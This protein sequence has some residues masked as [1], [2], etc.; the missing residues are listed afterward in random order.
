MAEQPGSRDVARKLERYGSLTVI[1]LLALVVAAIQIWAAVASTRRVE[2]IVRELQALQATQ[3]TDEKARQEVLSLKIENELKSFFWNSLLATLGPVV[4]TFG[5][6][7]GALL[8]LRNYLDARDKERLDRAAV[9]LNTTLEHLMKEEPR[10]RAVGVVGLQH[11][12]DPEEPRHHLRALSALAA[13]ARLEDDPE[14]LRG[15]RIAAEQAFRTLPGEVLGRV[16]W[17]GAK[18]RGLD[19]SGRSLRRIDLRDADLE[20]AD[21]A[22]CDLAGASLANARLNGSRLDGAILEGANLEYAD[23]AGASLARTN[24]KQAILHHAKVWRMNLEGADLGGALFDPDEIG[25]ELIQSWR[26]ARYDP[27]ILDRLVARYGPEPRGFKVLML[28]WEIPPLVAGG[29]WTASYHLVRNLR[30]QGAD[31]TVVVPW[32]EASIL[33][34]PFGCEVEVVPLGLVPPRPPE[35]S[36][37]E[38]PAWSPYAASGY[39]PAGPTP[40]SPY[41]ASGHRPAGP[42]PWSPYAGPAPYTPYGGAPGSSYAAM[43]LEGGSILLRLVDEVA[44]RFARFARRRPFDLIHAHD[45]VTFGAAEAAS[46]A[47]GKP[48]VAHLHSTE[49][50]RRAR[51]PDPMIEEIEGRGLQAARRVVVPSAATANRVAELYGVAPDRITTAPNPLSREE[52]AVSEMGRFETRRVVFLGRLTAQKGPDLFADLAATFRRRHGEAAF[53]MFGGGEEHARLLQKGFVE[54]RGSLDWQSRGLAFSGASAVVV[55]S[56]SEPFGMVVLEAMQHRVPVL[57]PQSAGVAEVVAAGI[58]IQPQD[59]PAVVEHLARLLSDRGHWQ[60]V[61]AAQSEAIGGYPDQG[62][63]RRVIEAWE[64]AHGSEQRLPADP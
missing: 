51:D 37:A 12:L 50:D 17:Q 38:G 27:G 48:W 15:I 34:S 54:L 59:V 52:V 32:D 10:Q 64:R 45:W 30:R 16:S 19:L 18:L 55:P 3:L 42:T 11:F 9:D 8:G 44:E 47:S 25:W 62:Y 14:V 63:E 4:A 13:A 20:D 49:R 60:Q 26:R 22:A 58:R 2:R 39:R 1:V 43:R 40:W 29:T 53:V 5:A 57:Y 36:W 41:A 21:L 56:R 6:V 7:I 24:L 23:L 46:R 61:V 33:P 31:V 28:M 35:P